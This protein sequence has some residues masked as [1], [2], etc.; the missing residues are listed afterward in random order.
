MITSDWVIIIDY[1][2]DEQLINLTQSKAIS[3]TKD[4]VVFDIKND[5]EPT[6]I[7]VK[8]PEKIFH[9]LKATLKA[10]KIGQ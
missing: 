5:D 6:I 10:K 4:S 8:D 7:N 9:M 3:I 2:G 1:K